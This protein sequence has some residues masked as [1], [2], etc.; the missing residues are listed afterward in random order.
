MKRWFSPRGARRGLKLSGL[1][2]ALWL[3]WAIGF[4]QGSTRAPNPA[5][6]KASASH[7]APPCCLPVRRT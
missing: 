4:T 5:A 2:V 6:P 7:S 1:A 3:C